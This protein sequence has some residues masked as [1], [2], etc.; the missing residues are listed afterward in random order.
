MSLQRF[1]IGVR[2][3]LLR[4]PLTSGPAC[5]AKDSPDLGPLLH[6]MDQIMFCVFPHIIERDSQPIAILISK[7][8]IPYGTRGGTSCP[9]VPTPKI[10]SLADSSNH[11]L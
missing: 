6:L 5:S 4:F 11:I 2:H 1:T 8:V 7:H 3:A 10:Q 9:E